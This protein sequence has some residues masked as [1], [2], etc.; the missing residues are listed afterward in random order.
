MEIRRM[1][2]FISFQP[3]EERMCLGC[4]E[5]RGEAPLTHRFPTAAIRD[6]SPLIPPPWGDVPVSFLRDIQ[7]I[8]DQH[9]IS[10][11]SGLKPA[12]DLDFSGGLTA[13]GVIPAF[14]S[15]RAYETIRVHELVSR[16]D[17]Y[18]DAGI[19]M[20]FDFG[21]HRSK[22]IDVLR[23]GEC[24][25]RAALTDDQMLALVTWVDANAPYHANFVR[26]R[27]EVEPYDLPADTQLIEQIASVHARRCQSC[28]ESA[29][30]TRPDWID[31]YEPRRS[32]FLV[33]PL[34]RSA[35]GSQQCGEVIYR[36]QQDPD[37]R[38]LAEL[39]DEAVRRAWER[40][41]RDVQLLPPPIAPRAHPQAEP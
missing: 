36:D 24:G 39:L 25:R 2:S 12:A 19:T 30:I 41:R 23:E 40:P 18:G 8:F 3:G 13:R 34:A 33:A 35:G 4:H 38:T 1:R 26:K 15:N 22:L 5:T 28:H 17:V 32:R 27:E 21:S 7:P 11:H 20:P 9:C 16:S 29:A 37:Y 10:C 14:G 31:M 6:P